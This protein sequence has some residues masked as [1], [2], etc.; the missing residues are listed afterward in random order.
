MLRSGAWL[1]VVSRCG[2]LAAY[3]RCSGCCWVCVFGGLCFLDRRALFVHGCGG[4]GAWVLVWCVPCWVCDLVFCGCDY[5]CAANCGS[6]VSLFGAWVCFSC[7]R[8]V[9]AGVFSGAHDNVLWFWGF[10]LRRGLLV[11]VVVDGYVVLWWGGRFVRPCLTALPAYE[12]ANWCA[13][14]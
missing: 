5:R 8:V 13:N 11:L 12:Y 9:V 10:C 6:G 1:V 4:V 2:Y 3:V 7:W 14:I